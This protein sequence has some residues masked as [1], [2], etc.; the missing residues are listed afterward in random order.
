MRVDSWNDINP[1]TKTTLNQKA[2]SLRALFARNSH[3]TLYITIALAF[4]LLWLVP[5]LLNRS[6]EARVI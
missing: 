5:Y 6:E 4:F 3:Q 2:Q 1:F